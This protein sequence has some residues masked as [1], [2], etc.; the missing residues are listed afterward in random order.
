MMVH[1]SDKESSFEDE[2]SPNPTEEESRF[3]ILDVV[4][5]LLFFFFPQII[6]LKKIIYLN[7]SNI[8]Y[9]VHYIKS[10]TIS[11]RNQYKYY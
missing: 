4:I 8:F 9:L 10:I 5:S 1:F 3:H 2:C 7:V 11:T 6:S